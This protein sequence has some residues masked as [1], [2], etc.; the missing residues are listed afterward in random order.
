MTNPPIVRQGKTLSPLTERQILIWTDLHRQRTGRWPTPRS[1]EI[2]GAPG[3]NWSAVDRALANGNRG[4]PGGSSLPKFLAHHWGVRNRM[5]LPAL[6]EE[7]ILAWAE[8]HFQSTGRWPSLWSGPIEVA[9]GES[10]GGVHAALYNGGRGLPGGSSLS[11]LLGGK[12]LRRGRRTRPLSEQQILAWADAFHASMGRWPTQNDGRIAGSKGEKWKNVNSALE[13]GARGLPG[14]SS[15]ARLLARDRGARNKAA[16][17]LLTIRDILAWAGAHRRRTGQWPTSSS[18]AVPPRGQ[19]TWSGINSALSKGC[20]GLPGG[21]SLARLL[22]E[23]R[24]V[25]NLAHVL[26]YTCAEILAWADEHHGRTGVWPTR[27]SGPIARVP[28]ES[29]QAVAL[30][31]QKGRRGLPGGSSLARLLSEHRGV[32]NVRQLPQI[33]ANQILAWADEHHQRTGNWPGQKSGHVALAPMENWRAINHAL[34]QGLRGLPGSS[35]LAKLLAE[36]RGVR[37]LGNLPP[38]TEEQI[39]SWADEHKA[40]TGVWPRINSGPLTQAAGETWRNIHSALALGN[41]GLPGGS[42]LPRLLAEHRVVCNRG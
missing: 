12:A 36:C 10:W 4:L 14:G 40:R 33:T 16:L 23:E 28:G 9:P 32:P 15:L 11:R 42:S 7:Q 22:E 1:G 26:P 30:A 18:G 38:L 27:D 2:S 20:R 41:R 39:L 31:L 6:T 17:P 24:G 37:N 35:S 29:W 21:S 8:A 3:E 34:T 5:G 13:H 19:E 25:R